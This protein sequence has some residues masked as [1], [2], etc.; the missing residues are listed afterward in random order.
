MLFAVVS[1]F[2]AEC[3]Q[4][5]SQLKNKSKAMQLLRAKLY[6]ARLEEETTKRSYARKIQ[7]G[8]KGRAEKIRTYNFPQD[9][10]TDHRIGKSLHDMRSFLLGEGSLDEMIQD[11]MEFADTESL[12]ELLDNDTDSKQEALRD[13]LRR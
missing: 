3:Q 6:S 1:G 9:R 13:P 12:L 2:V 4:E 8:T 10:I 7:I 11:L 5:R